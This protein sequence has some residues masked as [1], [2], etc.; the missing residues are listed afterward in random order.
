MK[1]GYGTGMYDTG[2]SP[3]GYVRA[4]LHSFSSFPV[5]LLCDGVLTILLPS[6]C[7]T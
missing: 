1:R 5:I 6:L 4:W 7:F 2:M 3:L